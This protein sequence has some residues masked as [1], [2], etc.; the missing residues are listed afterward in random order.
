MCIIEASALCKVYG[1]GEVQVDALRGVDLRVE[2]GE[3]VAIMGPSG[4]GKSTLLQMLGGLEMPT[5]GHVLIEDLDLAILNDDQRT[6][7]RRRRVGFI[8]QA[9]N[10]LP[11]LSAE[12][13]VRL[14]LAL[15]GVRPAQAAARSAEVLEQVG[16]THRARH[17]PSQLS[18]GEQ[19]RVAVARALVIRP[20]LLL[21]DEPTGN[22]DSAAGQ[23]LTTLMRRLVDEQAQTIVMVTHDASV[24]SHADR[25]IHLRDG[26]IERETCG[27]ESGGRFPSWQGP[28]L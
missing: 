5:S 2:R 12:E 17:L 26:L 27:A 28:G 4:C 20:V 18:G 3:F 14:P 9:F 13:N 21:A 1:S 8:F 7:L 11:T 10:L 15:D 23:N 22:L 6:L 24:A 19:Q 25:I 16:M